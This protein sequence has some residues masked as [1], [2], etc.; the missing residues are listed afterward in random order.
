MKILATSDLHG[1]LPMITEPFDLLFIVG[2]ICPDLPSEL[3]FEWMIYEFPIWVRS[4]PY[5]DETS[6]VILVWG[7]HDFI[8]ERGLKCAFGEIKSYCEGRLEILR[9]DLYDH[10]GIQIF[11]TPYCS[12][13]GSWAFMVEDETLEKKY[14]QIP[15]GVDFLLSHDSPNIYGLGSIREGK[16]KSETTG[17]KILSAHIERIKPRVFL[18]GHY[19]TGNH[20]FEEHDGTWMANVSYV[21]EGYWSTYPI[22]SFEYDEYTKEVKPTN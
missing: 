12:K 15:E 7:N 16:Y 11:G 21:N 6:K 4:L 19:H 1:N 3:Q 2:D 10:F 9:H 8:G 17:N 22:L 13:F 5:K 18:S 14:S 20:D